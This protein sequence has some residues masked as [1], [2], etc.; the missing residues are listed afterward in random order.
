ME[1]N[2]PKA[3]AVIEVVITAFFI[4]SIF[5]HFKLSKEERVRAPAE[6]TASVL[7]IETKSIGDMSVPLG[8]SRLL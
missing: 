4:L 2:S 6:C 7:D 5:Y 3:A 8:K 1:D